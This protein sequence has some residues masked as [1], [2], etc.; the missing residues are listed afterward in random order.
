MRKFTFKSLLVVAMMLLG[1]NY[2]LADSWSIDL[3]G[4]VSSDKVA[5]TV[6]S[7]NTITYNKTDLG[8][9]SYEK[10][11]ETLSLDSRLYLANNGN[12]LLRTGTNGLSQSARGDRYFAISDCKAGQIVTLTTST[13]PSEVSNAEAKN[14]ESS[15]YTYVVT[16]DGAVIFKFP[17]NNYIK[18]ISVDD[19]P[20]GQEFNYTVN[21]VC[22]T[23]NVFTKTGTNYENTTIK[24]PYRKYNVL[25]GVLYSKD[26]TIKEYNYSFVLTEDN[27][28]ENLEYTKTDINNVVFL[29]EGEDIEGMSKCSASNAAIRSSNSAAGYSTSDVTITTLAPG[30]YKI[31]VGLF[32]ATKDLN[33]TFVFTGGE[34]TLASFT[35]SVVNF[36]EFSSD[37]FT[38]TDYTDVVLNAVGG[39]NQGL[40]FIYITGTEASSIN[41]TIGETGYASLYYSD[42]AF[43][44]PE[45]VTAS[46]YTMTGSTLKESVTYTAGNVIPTGEAVVLN[47]TPG[48]YTF[49]FAEA[50][51]EKDANNVLLGCDTETTISETGYKYYMLSVVGDEVGFYYYNTDGSSITCAAHKVYLQVA[52]TSAKV[53][54]ALGEDEDATAITT[55]TTEHDIKTVVYDLQGRRV[56]SPVKG[57]YI[58][59]GKKIVK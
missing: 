28:V 3:T 49:N 6:S 35:T 48:D 9:G 33:T 58:V 1:S 5:V 16:A 10:D 22:N 45:G 15:P 51:T 44:V 13:T 34:E 59:N 37:E 24:V 40:D 20:E 55:V 7:E 53:G 41:V 25:D 32:D 57:I 38:L 21:Q 14:T 29:S 36:Q 46:T 17:N 47:G 26:A 50:T 56:M 43:E 27:Q 18:K 39:N 19:A 23:T 11:G 31:N 52:T 30:T 42:Y 54:Y 8:N 12:W 2:A 4:K